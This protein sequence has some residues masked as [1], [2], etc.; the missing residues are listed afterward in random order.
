MTVFAWI[1][2]MMMMKAAKLVEMV[3]PESVVRAQKAEAPGKDQEV[4]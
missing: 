2:R 3:N 4:V 1:G